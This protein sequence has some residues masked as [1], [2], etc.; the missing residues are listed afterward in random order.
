[1]KL[2]KLMVSVIAF[3]VFFGLVAIAESKEHFVP[4]DMIKVKAVKVAFIE[5][6]VNMSNHYVPVKLG[7]IDSTKVTYV[8]IVKPVDKVKVK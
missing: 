1:M 4:V 7:K 2:K 5:L 6:K 8:R 3:I